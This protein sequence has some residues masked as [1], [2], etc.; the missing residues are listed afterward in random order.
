MESKFRD[1]LINQSSTLA[2]STAYVYLLWFQYER[3]ACDYF[4]IPEYYIT[5]SI[6]GLL[7]CAVGLL[8]VL[9]LSFKSI[10]YLTPVLKILQDPSKRAWHG[11]IFVNIYYCILGIILAVAGKPTWKEWLMY[12]SPLLLGDLIFFI[13]YFLFRKKNRSTEERIK[14]TLDAMNQGHNIFSAFNIKLTINQFYLLIVIISLPFFMFY[15]GKRQV[16]S[17]DGFWAIDIPTRPVVLKRYENK[18]FCREVDSTKT[19]KQKLEI[20]NADDSQINLIQI[21]YNLQMK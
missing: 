19:F 2:F 9:A 16:K 12:A 4:G 8:T 18:L 1:Y 7:L 5:P 6:S 14:L 13:G 17:L 20:Y 21:K 10:A 11:I 3:G 15:L